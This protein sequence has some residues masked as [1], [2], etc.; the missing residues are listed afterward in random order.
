[1][2]KHRAILFLVLPS[3]VLIVGFLFTLIP[4]KLAT[5][6]ATA[7]STASQA[8]WPIYGFNSH[9]TNAN[10]FET[11]ISKSNASH[12]TVKWQVTHSNAHWSS[13]V[14]INNVLYIVDGNI[15]YALNA[16]SGKK[17]WS[18]N[19]VNTYRG[20]TPAVVN[21]VVYAMGNQHLLALN[22]TTGKQIWSHPFTSYVGVS[23]LV[24][25]NVV[26]MG[27][28]DE[29]MY[30]FNA[31]TGA[32]LWKYMVSTPGDTVLFA[33]PTYGNGVL[34]VEASIGFTSV[35]NMYTLNATTG[36][37]IWMVK[38]DD[39]GGAIPYNPTLVS[40]VVYYMSVTTLQNGNCSEAKVG[41][42]QSASG[43]SKWA[44]LYGYC[45]NGAFAYSNGILYFGLADLN[46]PYSYAYALNASDGTTK[47]QY[48]VLSSNQ[49]S[50]L[51][52]TPAIA[53]GIAYLALSDN[54]F[55]AFDAQIG[56]ILWQY[57]T[58]LFA[59]PPI[60]INGMVYAPASTLYAF[61]L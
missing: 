38:L 4:S 20:F 45:S 32:M 56:T 17:V 29:N 28:S 42:L 51:A 10:P 3:L 33:T 59:G 15:L 34:Y 49:L 19:L 24:V 37:L 43:Q 35:N 40:G 60:V 14:L 16:T 30:A 7:A 36:I 11:T 21:N 9:H 48:R 22:A 53:N 44:N 27:S 13:P 39:G 61:G 31:Q 57:T 58:D 8:N 18:V 46:D 47:W 12:L 23:P 2:A 52:S 6:H 5:L 41:A 50:Y 25:N 55:Y 26:Y 1:M 54:N